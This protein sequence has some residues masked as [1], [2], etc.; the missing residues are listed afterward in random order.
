MTNAP[1]NNKYPL[2]GSANPQTPGSENK[3][4]KRGVLLPAASRRT[5]SF[6]PNLGF[7]DLS[8]P[9]LRYYAASVPSVPHSSSP[10][11]AVSQSE[12]PPCPVHRPSW[13]VAALLHRPRNPHF[14]TQPEKRSEIRDS[15]SIFLQTP[16]VFSPVI[17]LYLM[18]RQKIFSMGYI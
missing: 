4:I 2:Q 6:S 8:I 18:P 3:R 17:S 7:V 13:A 5:I 10:F 14:R 16:K 15:Q 9:V 12:L 1:Q 11:A